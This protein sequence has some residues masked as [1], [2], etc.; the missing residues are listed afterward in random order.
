MKYLD[1]NISHA[2]KD[3]LHSK[4]QIITLGVILHIIMRPKCVL[5]C[6]LECVSCM[7][8]FE[9]PDL[10]LGILCNVLLLLLFMENGVVIVG[11]VK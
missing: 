6:L 10:V 8:S 3:H 7:D 5:R 9:F 1:V 4:Y 2:G 11:F